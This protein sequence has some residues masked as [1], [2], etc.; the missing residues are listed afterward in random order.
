MDFDTFFPHP[1]AKETADGNTLSEETKKI[2]D[3]SL[4]QIS[5][6]YREILVLYYYDELSYQEIADILQIPTATVGVR[7]K[8]GK[9]SLQKQ[10]YTNHYEL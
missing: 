8:R 3:T 10:L 9:E 6:K 5:L 7:L 4:S 1:F 2:L